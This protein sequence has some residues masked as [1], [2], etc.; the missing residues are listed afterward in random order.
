M[1]VPPL[2]TCGLLHWNAGVPTAALAALRIPHGV[3]RIALTYVRAS[4]LERRRP[5]CRSCGTPHSARSCAYRPYL[6]A[7]F[8]KGTRTFLSALRIPQ[9]A[10][11]NLPGDARIALAHA[12]AFAKTL[13]E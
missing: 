6:R 11:R 1:R 7:G 4:A 12:R 13:R 3:A 5:A 8:C 10:F 9:S 2:L